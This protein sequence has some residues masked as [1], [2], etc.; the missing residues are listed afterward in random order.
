MRLRTSGRLGSVRNI[1]MYEGRKP[2]SQRAKRAQP[3]KRRPAPK[4]APAKVQT[5]PIQ[6]A[7]EQ[8]AAALPTIRKLM[9]QK[10]ADGWSLMVDDLSEPAWTLGT[11]KKALAAA[12]READ[13][14]TAPLEVYA[15]NG[16]LQ[17]TYRPAS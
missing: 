8:Q 11:K 14:L 13:A 15:G 3:A 4:P 7:T 16:K 17:E 9:L 6:Q 5:A 2:A 1:R 10:A 12:R